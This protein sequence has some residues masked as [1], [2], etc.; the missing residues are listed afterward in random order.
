MLCFCFFK[1]HHVIE[2]LL[3]IFES[4][5]II[6][7]IEA[8]NAILLIFSNIVRAFLVLPAYVSAF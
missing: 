6:E 3:F 5:V 8:S 1:G 2:F 4:I 7:P